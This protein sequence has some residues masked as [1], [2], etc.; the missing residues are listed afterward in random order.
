MHGISTSELAVGGD[1]DG[2]ADRK[3]WTAT[4]LSLIGALAMTSC[5][6]LPLVL[7]SF[8]VTGVFIA[9][10]SAL[11]AYK[12]ITFTIS[13]AVLSYGFWKA[14]HP[15]SE[16]NCADGACARPIN[17]TVMRAILW[18]AAAIVAAAMVFPYLAPRVLSF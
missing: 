9:Q 12:W 7:V 5:C 17:R 2:A 1:D 4:G 18:V 3:G 6:I 10:F 15:V 13:A 14:Y 8:G 16:A 11:Y